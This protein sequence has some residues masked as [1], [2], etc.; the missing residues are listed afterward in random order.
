MNAVLMYIIL[1]SFDSLMLYILA[2]KAVVIPC[3]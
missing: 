3:L 2:N 1:V